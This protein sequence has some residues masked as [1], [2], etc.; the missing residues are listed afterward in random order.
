MRNKCPK[1]Q[2]ENPESQKYCGECATPLTGS[3]DEP[4]TKTFETTKEELTTGSLFAERYQIIEELGKGGMGKVY[5]A[6]DKELN[7]EVALK[8]IKPEIA[9]DKKVIERFKNELKLARKI[10]HPNIGRMYELLD[11]GGIHYITMEYVAGQDLRGLIRQSGQLTMGTIISFSEQLCEGL[12]EAHRLGIVHRDLK[13]NNIMV[14]K[15]GRAR[16]MD[17]G[18]A[19]SLKT[20]GITDA[21]VVFGTP[22]YM[23]PEQ[24]EGKEIDQT[25]DIYSLGI[26]LYEMATGRV[27]FT[28][29]TAS[30]IKVKNLRIRRISIPESPRN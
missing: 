13:P 21:G 1:C 17:F 20:K 9:V 26:I 12:A 28:G 4:L 15:E 16:I 25:S 29:E 5:R 22:E 8:L 27:P 2:T 11:Y 6:L 30:C 3:G 24:V 7:E 18:I 14:D 19:R 10:G 23:S